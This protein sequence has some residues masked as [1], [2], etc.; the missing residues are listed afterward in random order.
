MR[1]KDKRTEQFEKGLAA[2]TVFVRQN[3]HGD[4]GLH[5]E[6]EDGFMLGKWLCN[7]RAKY[8]KGVLEEK[9]AGELEKAGMIWDISRYRWEGYYNA[10]KE[11]KERFG[12]LDIPCR[13]VTE[14]GKKLGVWLNNQKNSYSEKGS[15]ACRLDRGQIQKLEA[16]GI[17]WEG[18]FESAWER[19]YRLAEEYYIEHGNL[20]MSSTY[21]YKGENLG[22]WLNEIRLSRSKTGFSETAL[23]EE[24][25]QRLDA[26]GMV[27]EKEGSWEYRYSLSEAYYREHG[28]LDI[29]QQYIS[30]GGIWLGK[31]LYMQRMQYRDGTLE[32]WKKER[33]DAIGMV[34]G[35]KAECAFEKGY[36][37]LE[38][39]LVQNREKKIARNYIMPDGYR[40]GSWVYRQKRKKREGKLTKEQEKKLKF[41]DSI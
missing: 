39:Y 9:E 17:S 26:I 21:I 28:N 2:L 19:K 5:Y 38:E 4:T 30:D 11:Y 7:M 23:P 31:W 36:R 25:I 1:W 37:A 22:K 14:D 8:K 10:A 6:T 29:S 13:Y 34:W 41:L 24:R 35:S 15:K 20:E 33:L 16:L 12:T 18:K 27:W 32:A 3:G 40:L